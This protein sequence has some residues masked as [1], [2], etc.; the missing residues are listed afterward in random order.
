M[1][2]NCEELCP[3]CKGE[4]YDSDSK[5]VEHIVRSIKKIYSPNP[6]RLLAKCARNLF[7]IG[8]DK[9]IMIFQT[10]LR[11]MDSCFAKHVS[12]IFP[13]VPHVVNS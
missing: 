8:R 5:E 10:T 1:N 11:L 13:N 9:Y 3:S 7:K 2:D 4:L 12:V 6:V